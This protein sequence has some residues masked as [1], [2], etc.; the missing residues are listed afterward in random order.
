MLGGYRRG[1][2]MAEREGEFVASKSTIEWTEASWNPVV[3]CTKVSEG[4]RNCYAMT[5]AARVA[6]AAWT[7]P[8]QRTERQMAYTSAVKW[9]GDLA[10]PQWSNEVVCIEGAL[11][12]P[13]KWRKQ[14]LVFVN[15][16]SDLFHESVPFEFIDRVF[17]TMALTPRHTYQILTK[18]PQRMAEYMVRHRADPQWPLPNVWLG[19]SVEH[20]AALKDRVY[21]LL[22]C[23]AAVRFLSCEPLLGPLDIDRAWLPRIGWVIVGAES[24]KGARPMDDAWASDIVRACKDAGVPVFVKQRCANGRKIPFDEWP[25]ELQV[26]EMPK[27]TTDDTR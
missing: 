27:G 17:A 18:R 21:A 13:R 11:D 20:R 1:R 3:G 12:E 7:M 15:S 8:T 10:L 4:C 25:E 5:M 16:M 19:V 23:P 9:R 26:R 24:G 22:D 14:R 6:N 2:G